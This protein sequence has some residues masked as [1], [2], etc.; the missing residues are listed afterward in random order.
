MDSVD[1]LGHYD[2]ALIILN[3]RYNFELWTYLKYVQINALFSIILIFHRL[4]IFDSFLF[5]KNIKFRHST[6][7]TDNLA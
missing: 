4:F 1:A 3:P 6:I 2:D 7:Q 5:Q